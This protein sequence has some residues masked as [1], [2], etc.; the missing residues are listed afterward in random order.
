MPSPK[1]EILN[2]VAT[3]LG[4]IS[5][6]NGYYTNVQRVVKGKVVPSQKVTP[7]MRSC[8]VCVIYGGQGNNP[9]QRTH[10]QQASSE[11]TIYISMSNVTST[12]FLNATD[13]I[14][15]AMAKDSVL[16]NSN[17]TNSNFTILDRYVSNISVTDSGELDEVFSNADEEYKD[18]AAVLSL[19]VTYLYDAKNLSGN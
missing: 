5:T 2:E 8:Y 13:D 11:Y 19:V 7:D 4:N 18:R 3:Q 9:T 1:Q 17:S 16:D 15:A 14:E 12:N 10:L 6:A